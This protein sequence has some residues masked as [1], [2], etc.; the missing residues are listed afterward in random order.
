[1]SLAGPAAQP[2][3]TVGEQGSPKQVG[4]ATSRPDSERSPNEQLRIGK[5]KLAASLAATGALVLV[6]FTVVEVTTAAASS[7]RHDQ[8][9]KGGPVTIQSWLYIV[10]SEN[11]L[12]GTLWACSKI[13]GLSRT[14]VA[15]RPGIGR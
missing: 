7:V 14:R 15:A 4:S 8:V 10:P 5:G 6:P 2:G 1:M 11:D 9:Q 3:G 13:T 12:A